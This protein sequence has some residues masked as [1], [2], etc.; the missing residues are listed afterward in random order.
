MT[1]R[2]RSGIALVATALLVVA[3]GSGSDSPTAPP[4]TGF[5]AGTSTNH[6]IGFIINS[7]GK[8]LT[9]FQLG[10]PATQKQIPLG[11]SS[12]VTP[13]SMSIRGRRVAIPLG[14]AASV[15]LIDLDAFTVQRFFTFTSGNTTGSAFVDD[16][17]IVAANPTLGIV[18]RMTVGQPNAAITFSVAVA[19]QPTA[20]S[21]TGGRVLVTSAN[22]D[23]NFAPIGN[24]IVTAIDP[25]TMQVLGKATMGGTNANDAAVGPDGLLYVVNTGDFVAPSTLTI[26]NPATMQVV[27]TVA[28]I[29]IGAGAISIDATGRAYISSFLT[30]TS[31]WDTKTRAFVRSPD[32][33]VCEKVG[34]SCLGAFAAASNQA[35]DVYQ[36]FFG[37]STR[38]PFVYVFKAGGY[39][40]SDSISVGVGPTFIAIRSF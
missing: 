7:T 33:P 22:L 28:S 36:V 3:C 26:L 20:I 30:G 29:G 31:V 40:L 14:D 27:T 24:S 8:A 2:L 21:V 38:A 1:S 35:G 6:E 16:T 19:P 25:K 15:A 10:S 34:G 11:T 9:L 5:L 4:L 12:T 32:N 23:A 18:G 17:T 39:A 13:V 37:S